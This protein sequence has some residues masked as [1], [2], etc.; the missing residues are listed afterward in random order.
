MWLKYIIVFF[1]AMI[2]DIVPLPLPPAFVVMVYW[3]IEFNLNVW[4]VIIV[5]VGGSVL[6]RYILT[7]YIPKITGRIFT[8][9]KNEDVQ[10]LGEK[11]KAERW[12]THLVIFIY[13]LL[14]LPTTPLFIAGGMAKMKPIRM[15]PAFFVG[16]FIS[17]A[18]AVL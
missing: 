9:E 17:D 7:Q 2:V 4:L 16:K 1:S 5:G 14:P 8:F 15:F 6:G 18:I 3:Q 10:F 12:K 13:S 11:L